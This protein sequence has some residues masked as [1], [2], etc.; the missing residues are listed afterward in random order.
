MLMQSAKPLGELEDSRE[1]AARHIG[2]SEADQAL[3]LQAVGAE[4]RRALMTR[5]V[6]ASITRH[7][8]MA[9][10][11]PLSEAAA[12]DELRAIAG[13]NQVFRSHIG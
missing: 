9:L 5:I 8:A 7:S 11:A 10:P 1:F 12:L 2:V 13:R 6:P 3:M 4:S